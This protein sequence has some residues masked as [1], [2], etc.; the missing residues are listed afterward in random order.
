[1]NEG[2]MISEESLQ[3]MIDVLELE[4]V[5]KM[6]LV[7]LN[8]L[9]AA[10][11]VKMLDLEKAK[12]WDATLQGDGDGNPISVMEKVDRGRFIP[13]T[14]L[15]NLVQPAQSVEVELL[16]DAM[17]LLTISAENRDEE[18]ETDRLGVVKKWEQYLFPPE[19]AGVRVK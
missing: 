7:L 13:I 14:D 2:R 16:A 12:R 5:R 8:Q 9:R 19:S 15:A 3:W 18:W 10:P 1:M 17:G 6:D 4:E 11:T